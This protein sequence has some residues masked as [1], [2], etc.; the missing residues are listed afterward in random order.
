MRRNI[1]AVLVVIPLSAALATATLAGAS[2]DV[3]DKMIAAHGGM[4]KWRNAPSV[5]FTDEWSFPG[6]PMT[7]KANIIV[8]QGNRRVRMDYP[9]ANASIGWDGEQCWS[10]NW[11]MPSPPRFL[12]Q[13]NYYFLN[14][15]WLM[16]DPGVVLSQPAR[17]RVFD[18]PVEYIAIRV[19]YEA[20]VGDTPDDYYVL[21]IHPDTYR[22]A[23]CRYVVT[24]PGLVPRGM[25]HTPEHILLYEEFA[26][27]NGLVVPTAYTIYETNR[28]EYAACKITNWSFDKPFD[29]A[30][31]DMPEGAVVDRSLERTGDK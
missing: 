6:S 14:L 13:L 17:E 19:T 11:Q 4:E 25:E 27:V 3:V 18:D 16:K 24:Y 7:M 30:L 8:E 10:L 28:D 29:D 22:L 31:V 5:S 21:Y 15:P 2:D 1:L 9:D 23:G 12:P 26:T 20:G